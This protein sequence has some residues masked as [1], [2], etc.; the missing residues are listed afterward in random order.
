MK[1][2]LELIEEKRKQKV[3]EILSKVILKQEITETEKYYLNSNIKDTD[4]SDNIL[5]VK[6]GKDKFIVTYSDHRFTFMRLINETRK[7]RIPLQILGLKYGSCLNYLQSLKFEI[8][9]L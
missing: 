6:K 7:K 3:T 9:E 5:I 4:L 8:D 2:E 1:N